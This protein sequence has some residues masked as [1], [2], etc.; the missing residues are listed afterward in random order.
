VS[1]SACLRRDF[2]EDRWNDLVD[3]FDEAWLWHRSE[4]RESVDFRFEQADHSFVVLDEAQAPL[5]IMP[6]RLTHYRALRVIPVRTLRSIGGPATANGLGAKLR[7]RILGFVHE[8]VLALASRLG[9]TDIEMSCPP[10]APALRGERCPRTNPLAW[11]GCS[12]GLAHTWVVDLRKSE[13]A[14]RKAY[15]SGTREELRRF[16]RE[17]IDIRS[18]LGATGG[19]T[20]TFHE[21]LVATFGRRDLRPHSLGYIRHIFDAFVSRGLARAMFLVRDGEVVAGNITA[22]YKGGA[23]YWFGASRYDR[24]GG[25]NRMLVDRQIVEAR[26]GGIEFFETGQACLWG[27]DQPLRGISDFKRSFGADLYPLFQGT[28][29]TGPKLHASLQVLE[30]S[31]QPR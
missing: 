4:F 30:A 28:I 9:V 6:L 31:R 18:D 23:Q 10:M 27:D 12:G 17:P 15:A 24:M 29:I 26:A 3:R 11:V 21:L 5:A 14:I 7:S 19:G 1:F 25:A 8:H 2:G 16:R 20:E 13:E 22:I